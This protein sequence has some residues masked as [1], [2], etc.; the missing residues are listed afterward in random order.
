MNLSHAMNLSHIIICINLCNVEN[1]AISGHFF[2]EIT[3]EEL[4]VHNVCICEF[5]LTM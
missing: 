2:F 5:T 3:L 1:C 4:E